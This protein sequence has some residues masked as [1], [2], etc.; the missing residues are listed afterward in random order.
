MLKYNLVEPIFA[1]SGPK[2]NF[3]TQGQKM[4]KSELLDPILSTSGPK[5][6]KMHCVDI[7]DPKLVLKLQYNKLGG[8]RL[9]HCGQLPCGSATQLLIKRPTRSCIAPAGGSILA[10]QATNG[11]GGPCKPCKPL[12]EMD[13]QVDPTNP[14]N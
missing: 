12:C 1:T 9:A 3:W 4:L 5:A 7:C 2:A 14:K 11:V 6:K 10:K 13:S 8:F